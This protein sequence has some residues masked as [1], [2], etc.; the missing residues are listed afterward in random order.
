MAAY[1]L[2]EV[3]SARPDA[4]TRAEL[5]A[6]LGQAIGGRTDRRCRDRRERR[7]GRRRSGACARACPRRRPA[8]EPR[9]STTYRCPLSRLPDFLEQAG[10]ACRAAMP[11]LRPC[12]FG[13]FGD[14]NIHFN[15]TQPADMPA[16]DFLARVG[17][18][19]PDRPRYRARPR[20]LDRGR[21][22]RR[23]DQ[24]RRARALRRSGG[25]RPDADGSRAPSTRTTC[26]IP[27]RSS[28]SGRSSTPGRADDFVQRAIIR[29]AG[30][31]RTATR[32]RDPPR[33]PGVL[34]IC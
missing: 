7:P 2:I 34:S 29:R 11:G 31:C 10:A 3:A 30:G 17:A 18:V 26:S 6:A 14:G 28:P 24:A 4:D 20:R 5:E 22:R 32:R 23:P 1:A 19:Q 15:L 8:R 33:P 12:G 27:G 16:A 25:A 13:H 21:A 9:S